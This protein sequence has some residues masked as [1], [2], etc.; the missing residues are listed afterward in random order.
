MSLKKRTVAEH[1]CDMITTNHNSSL[2]VFFPAYNDAD[3][4]EALVISALNT[5]QDLTSDYEV[6]VVD[7]G[8]TD[9]TVAVLELLA[10]EQPRLKVIRHL[11]NRGYGAALRSGFAN[12]SKDLV[13]YTD[14]DGQYDPREL[15]ALWPLMTPG[16]DIVNGYKLKR[17]DKSH[18]RVLGGMY[19]HLAR[20]FFRLPIRDVDCDFRLLRRQALEQIDL[21]SSSGIICVEL[22]RKLHAAGFIFMEAPVNHYPRV[23]GRS[24]FFTPLSVTRT[25][26][27]FAMFWWRLVVLR[28]VDSN[29]TLAKTTNPISGPYSS[30][31]KGLHPAKKSKGISFRLANRAI[32]RLWVIFGG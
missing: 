4:I 32:A 10:R 23:H 24:Q 28:Q 9:N 5:L 30:G 1:I 6:L 13:F 14:G 27:D 20:W 7:D 3:V 16:I 17:A 31:L 26:F 15:G 2:T 29:I 11:Q 8:S 22:V 19:N 12:A 25:A 18:R 21:V